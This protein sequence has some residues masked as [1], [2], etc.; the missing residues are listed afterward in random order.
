MRFNGFGPLLIEVR[1][2]SGARKRFL[3]GS[4]NCRF[5]SWVGVQYGLWLLHGDGFPKLAG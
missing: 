4:Q 2:V 5:D 1:P 3:D